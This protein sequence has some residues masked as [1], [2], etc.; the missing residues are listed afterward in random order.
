MLL[1][2]FKSEAKTRARI[3]AEQ[4]VAQFLAQGGKIQQIPIGVSTYVV[5]PYS[6][7]SNGVAKKNP[8]LHMK[9]E[10]EDEA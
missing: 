10:G 5:T 3:A 6:V 8:A 1:T 9:D 4:D 2:D 7:T